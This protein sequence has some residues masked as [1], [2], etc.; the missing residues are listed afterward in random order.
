MEKKYW[1]QLVSLLSKVFEKGCVILSGFNV[2]IK[3][4]AG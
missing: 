1:K 2:Q 4:L 3:N